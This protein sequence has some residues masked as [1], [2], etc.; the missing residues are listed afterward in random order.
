MTATEPQTP[1]V[2]EPIEIEE[3]GQK[4]R[5]FRI[6]ELENA[7]R[8][9]ATAADVAEEKGAEAE[10]LKMGAFSDRTTPGWG[11]TLGALRRARDVLA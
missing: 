7:L 6:E 4:Y 2:P 8:P 5:S 3:N 1:A 11:I 10:R 9:F